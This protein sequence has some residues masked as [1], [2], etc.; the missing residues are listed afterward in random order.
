MT[1]IIEQHAKAISDLC[2]RYGVARLEVFGSAA[3]DTFDPEHSD[4]DLLVEFLPGQDLGPWLAQ[5]FELKRDL[6]TLL[7]SSV[8]LVM[9]GVLAT[10]NPYFAREVNRSRRLVYAA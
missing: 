10:A 1:A 5:Y 8:D 4:I 2:R 7:G 9:T 3:D 6:E